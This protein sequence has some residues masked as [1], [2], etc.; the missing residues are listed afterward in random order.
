MENEKN[1]INKLKSSLL[2]KEILTYLFDKNILTKEEAKKTLTKIGKG[3]YSE[4]E[5][6]SFLTVYLMRKITPQELAGFREALLDL[7]VPVDLGDINT[8]DVCGTGGDEKN[9][10]NIST[11][12][13]FVLAGIGEKVAKHGNYG[14]SSSCGSS[15]IL[16]YFGYS[17]SNDQ[18]KIKKEIDK[19]NICYLH[20]PLFHPAMKHVGPVRKSLKLKTFF[21][22][23]GPMVNPSKPKNQIIGVFD[24]E[25]MELYHQVYIETGMNYYILYSL[26]G[27]D[28]IS[29][30]G[31]FR[32]ISA[33]EKKTYKPG[34]LGFKNVHPG[35]ILGG[36]T[37]KDAAKIFSNIL[38]GKGT[39][40]QVNVVAV[41]AAF[42]IRCIHPD[43]S[44]DQCLEIAF[45]SIESGKAGQALK[46]LI[47]LQ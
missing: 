27:Y 42:A 19:V 11:L 46:K 15:N 5:I 40:A 6:A 31:E 30:T 13:A 22:L 35:D 37:V 32:T 8:I 47:A 23:L 12:T 41:N 10:F 20:A 24:E 2:M 16:E 26:D 1:N 38:S 18:E 14:V 44:I 43:K 9:T 21:N 36:V 7:C 3:L 39:K 33:S 25:V 17:F 28:E 45:E 4:A 34:D 29:L